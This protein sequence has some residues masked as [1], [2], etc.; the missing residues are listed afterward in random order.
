MLRSPC[1]Q[2]IAGQKM[3]HNDSQDDKRV[4]RAVA[5]VRGLYDRVA[6]EMNVHPSYVSRVARG[7]RTSK[8]IE[9][10][11]RKEMKRVCKAFNR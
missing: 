1:L 7:E 10:A 8:V 11:L 4:W 6:K 2:R 5:L 9:A 3:S